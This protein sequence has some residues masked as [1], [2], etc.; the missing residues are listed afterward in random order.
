MTLLTTRIIETGSDKLKIATL[1]SFKEI[2]SVLLT[3]ILITIS[4]KIPLKQCKPHSFFY[5]RAFNRNKSS[6]EN[7]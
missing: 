2:K 5:D 7:E 4:A 1:V 3:L 6:K